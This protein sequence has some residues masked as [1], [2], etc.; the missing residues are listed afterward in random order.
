MA[1]ESKLV[2]AFKGKHVKP[3]EQV[4][5]SAEGYIGKAMGQG[6]DTQ[7]NGA[8]IVTNG[9]VAFYR[10]GFLGE[11]IETIEIPKITSVERKSMMGHRTLRL[12][13]S[14]DDLEFKTFKKESETALVEAIE[15]RRTGDE[16][17]VN[18][19]SGGGSDDYL[20]KIQKLAE[21][22][23]SGVLTNEEFESKKAELMERV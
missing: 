19:D 4:V 22:R 23:D 5:C 7:H 8:L 14:H 11:V 18:A 12:H 2:Q 6:E 10:K 15:A 1:K 13:T 16:A 9:R 17:P 20:R 21:L 3:G